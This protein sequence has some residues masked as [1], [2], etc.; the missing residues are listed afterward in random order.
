M[1][2]A[3]L[4]PLLTLLLQGAFAQDVIFKLN[5]EEIPAKV[6]EITLDAVRYKLPADSL[7]GPTREVARSDVFMIRY[8]N[9]IRDVFSE[10]LPEAQLAQGLP[11]P[12]EQLYQKGQEDALLLY[13]GNDAFW[14][15]AGVSCAYWPIGLLGSALIASKPPKVHK[16][17]VPDQSL[18]QYPDYVRG[19]QDQAHR[20]KKSRATSGALVSTG[21]YV[22][23][24]ALLL[25]AAGQ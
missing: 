4:L 5:G 25:A 9:G 14:G 12:P 21:I 22:G 3:L 19:Y 8:A 10:N 17:P 1:K 13:K 15:S 11:L 18:L 23:V 6:L 7:S 16:Q 2:V 24:I 20:R